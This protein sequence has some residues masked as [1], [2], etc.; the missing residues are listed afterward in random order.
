MATWTSYEI[1]QLFKQAELSLSNLNKDIFN[2]ISLKDLACLGEKT[3]RSSDALRVCWYNVRRWHQDPRNVNNKLRNACEAAF[4]MYLKQKEGTKVDTTPKI[5]YITKVLD[6]TTID[7][8]NCDPI[9]AEH[10]KA[11]KAILCKVWDSAER[12]SNDVYVYKYE[13]NSDWPYKTLSKAEYRNAKPLAFVSKLKKASAIIKECEERGFMRV[14]DSKGL[15]GWAG[16]T[17]EDKSIY[18]YML[19]DC[20]HYNSNYDWPEWAWEEVPYEDKTQSS[21]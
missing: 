17:P 4:S 5:S 2:I 11:S 14:R 20:E 9:I 10:L 18:A 15:V 8:S 3:G 6:Y 7:Y 13:P 19:I 21:T 16:N 12:L 1:L